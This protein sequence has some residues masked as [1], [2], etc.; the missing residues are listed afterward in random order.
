MCVSISGLES[1]LVMPDLPMNHFFDLI[2]QMGLQRGQK[3]F[4][5]QFFYIN[6]KTNFAFQ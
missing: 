4:V 1:E 5:I 3:R 2:S 6:C